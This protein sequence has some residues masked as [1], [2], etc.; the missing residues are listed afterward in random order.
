MG[1]KV[2]SGTHCSAIVEECLVRGGPN[3]VFVII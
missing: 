3:C 1:E 2:G